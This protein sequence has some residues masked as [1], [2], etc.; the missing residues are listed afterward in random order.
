MS[1]LPEIVHRVGFQGP[2][3]KLM[4]VDPENLENIDSDKLR[5]WHNMYYRPD[6]MVIA[7]AG[8]EHQRAVE[9]VSKVKKI[10][11]G[12]ISKVVKYQIFQ[13]PEISR[14]VVPKIP[15]SVYVGGSELFPR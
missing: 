14:P 15:K 12:G 3:S 2:I 1:Y 9:L 11:V 5:Q 8:E 4:L 7:I 6:R 13:F 10:S